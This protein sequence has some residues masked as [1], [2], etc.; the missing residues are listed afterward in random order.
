VKHK[1]FKLNQFTF[2][3]SKN[4]SFQSNG[5]DFFRFST[6]LQENLEAEPYGSWTRS[7]YSITSLVDD[8][9]RAVDDVVELEGV[10]GLGEA[11]YV[12]R[13]VLSKTTSIMRFMIGCTRRT[14]K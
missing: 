12:K 6:I 3:K 10:V 14:S 5:S 13:V 7:E 9:E 2:L 4:H 11:L 8:V 1:S